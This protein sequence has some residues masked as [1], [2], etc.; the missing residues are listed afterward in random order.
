MNIE[1][2]GVTKEETAYDKWVHFTH[3]GVEYHA[4][5]HWDMYDGFD[6]TFT[7]AVRTANW[8]KTP[9]WAVEWNED[10]HDGESLELLLDSLTD[11]VIEESY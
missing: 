9:D 3:E 1:I 6:L 10:E 5:L 7:D 4:L 11:R 2:N 8:V